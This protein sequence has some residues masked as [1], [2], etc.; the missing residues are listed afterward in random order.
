MK[1]ELSLARGERVTFSARAKKV[2]K[3]STVCRF[4]D[5]FARSHIPVLRRTAHFL[6][7][8]SAFVALGLEHHRAHVFEV[9]VDG[10]YSSM[11]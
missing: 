10:V 1:P 7:A 2:T 4:A 8:V 5:V 6:C 11:R 3:E 9:F